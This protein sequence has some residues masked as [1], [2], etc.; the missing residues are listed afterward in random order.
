MCPLFT[1]TPP[2]IETGTVRTHRVLRSHLLNLCKTRCVRTAPGRNVM[3]WCRRDVRGHI[4]LIHLGCRNPEIN[5]L[6]ISRI[7]TNRHLQSPVRLCSCVFTYLRAAVRLDTTS[8]LSTL[9]IHT[10]Y[11]PSSGP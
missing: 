5:Y 9:T 3:F 4:V 10:H 7:S 11:F 8:L 6:R 1:S 2:S